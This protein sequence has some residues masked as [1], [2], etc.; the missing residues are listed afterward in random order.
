MDGQVAPPVFSERSVEVAEVRLRCLEAGQGSALVHLLAAGELRPTRAHDL[1]SRHRRV[2]LLEVP[3]P[4][5][6]PGVASTVLRAIDRLGLDTIDVAGTSAA[7]MT[8]LALT[9]Q[10]PARVRALVLESPPAH[11][12]GG[13]GED[14]ERRLPDV[15]APTLL[16]VGTRDDAVP[17]ATGRVYAARIPTCHL[18]FVYAAGH[19]ISADRPEAFTEVVADFLERHEAFVIS[20]AHTLI[21]P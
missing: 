9:L 11:G 12:P 20:R 21:H 13:L 17:P 15:V 10:A 3:E 19:A 16:L 6:S 2:V 8:A 4:G 1:L 18:V 14:L 5:R 7:A